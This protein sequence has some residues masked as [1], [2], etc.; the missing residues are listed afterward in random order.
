MAEAGTR[1]PYRIVRRALDIASAAG[2]LLGIGA[3]KATSETIGGF[4]TQ[5]LAE[6]QKSG[7]FNWFELG[8]TARE[9]VAQGGNRIN[10]QPTG[11]KFHDLALVAITVNSAAAIQRMDLVLQRSF[12]DSPGDG[13]FASDIA[14]SFVA[15]V[16]PLDDG[17]ALS[18]LAS[19]IQYRAKS[20]RPVIVGP[21][22]SAPELPD[23]PTAAYETFAGQRRQHSRKLSHCVFSIENEA[24]A[25]AAQLR[26]SFSVR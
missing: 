9:P 16:P 1:L 25:G 2:R 15:D 18:I 5:P 26:I 12:I 13:M 22:Y 19:E 4:L 11:D 7:F 20:S 17:E 23:P 14:K 6:I 3:R 24:G 10:F 21:G 8:E